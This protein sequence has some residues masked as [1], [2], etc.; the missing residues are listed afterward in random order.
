MSINRGIDKDMWCIYS[1]EE[2][3]AIKTTDIMSAA[4]TWMNLESL[5]LKEISQTKEGKYCMTSLTC[6]IY[7]ERLQMYKNRF[8]D[9]VN[10]LI[11]AGGKDG[12]EG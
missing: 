7:K 12:E 3:S 11:V 5:I 2:Y 4:A 8:T 10:E 9:F 6:G 1:R